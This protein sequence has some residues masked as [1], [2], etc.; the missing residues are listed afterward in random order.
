MG[1]QYNKSIKRQRRVAY[2]KRKKDV[3]KVKAKT[4]QNTQIITAAELIQDP[5]FS[6]VPPKFPMIW[7]LFKPSIFIAPFSSLYTAHRPVRIDWSARA[8]VRL[9][10]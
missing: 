4:G 8:L 3:A 7:T 9:N 5:M 2:L 10:C 1:K 6:G